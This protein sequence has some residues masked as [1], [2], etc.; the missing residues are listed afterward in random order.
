MVKKRNAV[1]FVRQQDAV[2]VDGGKFVEVVLDVYLGNVAL[3]KLERRARDL[4]VHRDRVHHL[5][6]IIDHFM[7]DSQVVSNNILCI[8]GAYK[9]CNAN[10]HEEK[11]HTANE[12]SDRASAAGLGARKYILSIHA[13]S[14]NTQK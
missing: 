4:S 11:L 10:N 1:L 13:K 2:P 8:C 12:S 6:R 7:V 5:P 3:S 14:A 9:C